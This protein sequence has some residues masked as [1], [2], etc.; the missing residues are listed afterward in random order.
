MRDIRGLWLPNG[1]TLDDG[2]Y[3]FVLREDV[4]IHCPNFWLYVNF[5]TVFIQ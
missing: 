5:T 2:M 3:G 4:K 1:V